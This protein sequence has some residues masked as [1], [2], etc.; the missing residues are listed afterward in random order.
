MNNLKKY[1]SSIFIGTLFLGTLVA[2]EDQGYDEYEEKV[3]PTVALNGEWWIDVSDAEGNVYV[4]HAL[5]RTYDPGDNSGRMMI[6][7]RLAGA[8]PQSMDPLDFSGW[9]L[10]GRVN[11]DTQNL[12]FNATNEFNKADESQFTIT[13]GKIIKGVVETAS[14]TMTDSIYF[15]G[16]FDYDPETTIVFA[17]HKRTGFEEDEF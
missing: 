17:G 7:D 6:S 8:D 14:G 3:T 1:L 10:E 2:C 11:V 9:M 15:E 16:V 13:N 4:Q 5:H 12:T